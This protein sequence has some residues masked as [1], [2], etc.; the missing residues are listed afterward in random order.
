MDFSFFDKINTAKNEQTETWF[1]GL[2]R[3]YNN[4]VY[5]FLYPNPAS[6]LAFIETTTPTA[7][8]AKATTFRC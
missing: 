3:I 4:F 1:K 5:D 2:D 8:W 7:S 6:V